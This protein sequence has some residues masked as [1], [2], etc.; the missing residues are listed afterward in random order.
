LSERVE[1]QIRTE[2]MH[3][4]AEEGIAAHWA[5]K[6]GKSIISRPDS[7]LK[8]FV[9]PTDEELMI[10]EH[11]L[12]VISASHCERARLQNAAI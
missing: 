8:V 2:E 9:I 11:T 10:A 6:E 3:T 5:Y 12:A 7:R 1:V 4:I